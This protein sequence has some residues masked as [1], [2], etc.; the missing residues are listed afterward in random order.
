MKKLSILMT[1]LFSMT[2][3][4]PSY[5]DI[6][7]YFS[8]KLG[9]S[10]KEVITLIDVT[11]PYNCNKKKK[12]S[13]KVMSKYSTL[14]NGDYGVSKIYE[15]V[16]NS[17]VLKLISYTT[18]KKCEIERI[19]TLSFCQSNGN[20]IHYKVDIPVSKSWFVQ[21][22]SIFDKSSEE[23]IGP[24]KG[25]IIIDSQFKGRL[26]SYETVNPKTNLY[27]LSWF[28]IS[29]KNNNLRVSH[30]FYQKPK[31]DKSLYIELCPEKEDK[32]ISFKPKYNS[33]N[34][35]I[36]TSVIFNSRYELS[37]KFVN[38]CS[39]LFPENKEKH[40]NYW[41]TFKKLNEDNFNKIKN[42]AEQVIMSVDQKKITKVYNDRKRSLLTTFVDSLSVKNEREKKYSLDECNRFLK[43]PKNLKDSLENQFSLNSVNVDF[44]LNIKIK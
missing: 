35:V 24:N 31:D 38:K 26:V 27:K 28:S 43:N 13:G 32:I 41:K 29:G 7:D 19:E 12:I 10:Y 17:E 2:F 8:F 1:I 39:V 15:G 21:N 22:N 14:Y 5:G 3:T 36:S 11:D 40:A 42:K 37:R 18:D 25:D 6:Q 34:K 9:D 44:V 4:F 20:L 33:V 16:I 23:F 30:S